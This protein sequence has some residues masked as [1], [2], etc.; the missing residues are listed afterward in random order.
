MNDENIL[1]DEN[2]WKDCHV[3][4]LWVY[5]K[6]ILA[7]KLGYTCGPVGV[8]VPKSGRY[9]IRPITNMCG[10]GIGAEFVWIDCI[11]DH[12]PL[13]Y[14]WCEV[15]EGRHLSVDYVNGKQ[16][17][18]V[19]GFRDDI[20]VIYKWSKWIRTEDLIPFPSIINNLVG[21]YPY[22]NVEYID[23][24]V[25]EIHLR[26]SPDFIKNK[27]T[28]ELYV[29]WEGESTTPPPGMIFVEDPDYKRKGFFKYETNT[30]PQPMDG[31]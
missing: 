19:E 20:N 1:D 23:G 27:E 2:A 26:H 24:K 3:N 29:V 18:C 15:F 16:T 9:I 8:D 31:R 11:T 28:K 14:F 4:D 13:G 12:L 5:D 7:K 21:K 30:T 17:I 25:I 10:M 22:V 6:L